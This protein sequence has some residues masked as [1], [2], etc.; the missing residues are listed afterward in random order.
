[1]FAQLGGEAALRP[2]IDKFI[3]RVFDD[4]MIGFFFRNVS[5]AHLKEKEFE[6][7]ARHLGADIEYTGRPIA[8]AHA[9]HPIMGGQFMR[10]LKIL[11]NTLDEVGV[12][13]H[14]K[15]HW[16]EHTERLRA[17][18]TRDSGGRCDPIDAMAKVREGRRPAGAA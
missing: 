18:V 10:R 14:I 9:P 1:M 7:A 5:R 13:E 12:P 4:V 17:Q 2:I 15:Q 8:E 16:L 3:D 11:E 6:F